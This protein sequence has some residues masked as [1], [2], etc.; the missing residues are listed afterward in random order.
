MTGGV[1]PASK[2]QSEATCCMPTTG[3]NGRFPH[4]TL[5]IFDKTKGK[6]W[7]I[8]KAKELEIVSFC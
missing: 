3:I 1:P 6:I 2:L 8:L 4:W 7:I 5:Y